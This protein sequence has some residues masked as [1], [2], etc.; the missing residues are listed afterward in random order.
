MTRFC[1]GLKRCAKHSRCDIRPGVPGRS[2]KSAQVPGRLR[3]KCAAGAVDE[4]TMLGNVALTLLT[5]MLLHLLVAA[6]W[7][8]SAWSLNVSQRAARHWSWSALLGAGVMAL[9]LAPDLGPV[10]IIVGLANLLSVASMLAMRRG[11]L[12]FLRLDACDRE[13]WV[14]LGLAGSAMALSAVLPPAQAA[15]AR[16]ALNCV[17]LLWVLV[18]MAVQSWPVLRREYAERMAFVIVAPVVAAASLFALR[19]VGALVWPPQAGRPLTVDTGFNVAVTM[20]LLLLFLLQHGGLAMV[21]LLRM[22]GKLRHLSQRDA[23]TGLFNRAEWTRQLEAQH[24]WLGRYGEPFALLMIDV[25]HFKK[26]NDTL[27]HAAGDAVLISIAQVLTASARDVDVVGR[28]GGEEFCVLLPRADP[29]SARRA[30]ERLRL[31]IGETEI[32]WRQ[33]TIR[34]TVSIGMALATDAEE[35]PQQVLDRADQALYQ[36]K[37]TGRNRSSMARA[38]SG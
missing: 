12:L 17:A 26:V 11:L 19:L 8:F 9:Y 31:A 18:R 5:M 27:G 32:S 13:A 25:D 4:E 28:I 14:V 24:R 2:V 22:V 10:W 15:T 37:R 7:A 34:L 21:V 3:L 38:V 33:N 35:S 29:V 6:V 23:L 30:A 20:V 16:V 1:R 36:A